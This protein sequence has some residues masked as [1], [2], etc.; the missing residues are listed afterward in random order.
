MGQTIKK[1]KS[2]IRIRLDKPHASRIIKR[3]DII[4]C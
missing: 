2:L 4:L 1:L 3:T